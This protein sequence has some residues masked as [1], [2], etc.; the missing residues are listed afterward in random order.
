MEVAGSKQAKAV[1]KEQA[2]SV[3]DNSMKKQKI[4][5][6]WSQAQSEKEMQAKTL[7]QFACDLNVPLPALIEWN[8]GMSHVSP[9]CKLKRYELLTIPIPT[10][11]QACRTT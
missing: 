7:T 9:T 8:G 10:P 2:H 5:G 6:D 3:E 4:G 1:V 11:R